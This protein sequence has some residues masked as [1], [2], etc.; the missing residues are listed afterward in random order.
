MNINIR[1]GTTVD[2]PA[3]LQFVKELAAFEKSSEKVTNTLEQM[4]EEQECFEFLVAEID[5]QVVGMAV[6]FFVYYTWVGKSLYLDDLYIDPLFRGQKIGSALLGEVFQV[7]RNEN[8][9]RVRWQVLDW[10][11]KAI[12]FYK[13]IGAEVSGQW[14]DCEFGKDEI[15]TAFN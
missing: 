6:Y 2:L 7:A 8:C 3:L 11:T 13:K 9:K 5:G 15:L 10:N 4:Q 1:S 12:E 14:L